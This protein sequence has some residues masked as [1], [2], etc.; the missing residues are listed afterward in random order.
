VAQ[1]DAHRAE[2]AAG[3]IVS[4]VRAV[5]GTR[6]AYETVPAMPVVGRDRTPV[7]LVQGLGADRTG[8]TMQ[9]IAFSP[10]HRT[11]LL[12]NRGAG[13]S[14]KP[15]GPY[16]LFDMA[17][18]VVAVLDDAGIGRAHVVGA[19]MGGAIAQIL[20]VTHP[21]RVASLTLA[22]T[23][24]RNHTWRRELLLEWADIATT[25]GMRALGHAAVRW[26]VG[27]R[28]LRRFAPALGLVAPLLLGAP[29]HGF[30]AQVQGILAMDD[31]Q[32]PDALGGI[33][34][35]T[36]VVVGNQDVLTPRGDAEEIAERIAGAEL[37]VIAGA[38]HGLMV[39]H[40]STFNRIVTDFVRRVEAGRTVAAGHLR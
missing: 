14:D 39:E 22:C 32:I 5:D 13:R 12:D 28:S 10:R 8:W 19:S 17:A 33:D 3:G 31:S 40:A 20:A 36:L 1:R 15:A 26:M 23:A 6:I 21:E 7:V 34:V 38:A 18:D 35:P 2:R 16:S 25:Q 24:C 11:V 37:A 29:A 4:V 30:V 27:P 9:R